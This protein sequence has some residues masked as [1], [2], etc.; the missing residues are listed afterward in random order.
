MRAVNLLPK[1]SPRTQRQGQQLPVLAGAAA[2]VLVVGALG[3]EFM[4]TGSSIAT[5]QRAYDAARAQLAATPTPPPARTSQQAALA[6]NESARVGALATALGRRVAW[7]RVLRELDFVLPDDVWLQT[8]TATSPVSGQNLTPAAT[9]VVTA[10][11][12]GL[13]LDGYTYS[14]ASV[15]RLLSRLQ[16]IPDLTNVQLTQ[17]QVS[18]IAGRSAV[19][20]TIA[21]DVR[22]PGMG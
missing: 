10:A 11:P 7:D 19:Q 1:D 14:Q 4:L 9:P 16:V 3:A 13:T 20:F 5:A 15:A 12:S 8:L 6:S 22:V 2:V 17:S 21:A 18:N